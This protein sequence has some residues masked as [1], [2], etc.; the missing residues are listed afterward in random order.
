MAVWAYTTVRCPACAQPFRVACR[1][2]HRITGRGIELRAGR[3]DISAVTTHV[4]KA[5]TV[6]TTHDT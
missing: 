1:I 6:A 4:A 5:H 3:P 2:R